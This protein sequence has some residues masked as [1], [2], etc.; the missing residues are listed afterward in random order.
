MHI[1]I[2]VAVFEDEM[3]RCKT[4][5]YRQVLHWENYISFSFHIEWDMI[6]G[7]VFL[8]ISNQMEFHLIQNWKE[9]CHHNLIPFNVKGNEK[10]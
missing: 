4:S 2:H 7:T 3:V 8:S 5:A 6:V 1:T 9:T 10:I